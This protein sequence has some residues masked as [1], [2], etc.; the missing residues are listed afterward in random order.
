METCL[1]N[2]FHIDSSTSLVSLQNNLC[3]MKQMENRG[4]LP[5]MSALIF[6]IL[7]YIIYCEMNDVVTQ[8]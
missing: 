8:T 4:M 2:T 6:N 3:S 5:C 7:L 1:T